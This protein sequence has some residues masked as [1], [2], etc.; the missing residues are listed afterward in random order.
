MSGFDLR[1][2]LAFRRHPG[3][4]KVQNWLACEGSVPRIAPIDTFE[5]TKDAFAS[6]PCELAPPGWAS[7][8]EEPLGC[9]ATEL[10]DEAIFPIE[11]GLHRAGGDIGALIG[12]PVAVRMQI[13]IALRSK[14][15]W[16][17]LSMRERVLIS[18][19]FW[20]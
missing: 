10:F 19:K 20:K 6:P 15:S 1:Q 14:L 7:N 9:V 16:H 12:T 5:L 13:L 3:G 8:H 2:E 11:I 17:K 4:L 18:V